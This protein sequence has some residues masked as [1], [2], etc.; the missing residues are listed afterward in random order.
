[1]MRTDSSENHMENE[2]S[3]AHSKSDEGPCPERAHG[4]EAVSSDKARHGK[5]TLESCRSK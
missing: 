4:P 1:M 2:N 3:V 5:G